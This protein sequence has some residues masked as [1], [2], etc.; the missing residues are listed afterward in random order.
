MLPNKL[1]ENTFSAQ[2][3]NRPI[4]IRC[5]LFNLFIPRRSILASDDDVIDCIKGFDAHRRERSIFKK[6]DQTLGYS[7][8]VIGIS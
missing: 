8:I 7:Y 4:A 3:L 2:T 5:S 1:S 6:I